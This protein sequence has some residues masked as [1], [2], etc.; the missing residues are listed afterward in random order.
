LWLTAAKI[1][2]SSATTAIINVIE[3]RATEKAEK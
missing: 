1:D 3:M 2:S